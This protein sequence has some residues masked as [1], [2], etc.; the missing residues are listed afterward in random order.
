WG[1]RHRIFGVVKP[2]SP[3][4]GMHLG[5]ISGGLGSLFRLQG[6]GPSWEGGSHEG[7]GVYG[8]INLMVAQLSTLQHILSLA[9]TGGGGVFQKRRQR[10]LVVVQSKQGIG[11]LAD[12]AG[13]K[14][15]YKAIRKLETGN[16]ALRS[17]TVHVR[18]VN[19]YMSSTG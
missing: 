19:Y 4:L 7:E 1:F 14:N 8:G 16:Q 12:P 10:N 3:F 18:F 9:W 2:D 13:Q 17:K 15:R 11:C 6:K 5:G